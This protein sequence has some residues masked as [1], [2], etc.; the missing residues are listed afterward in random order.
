VPT[1]L[2]SLPCGV[3]SS[4]WSPSSGCGAWVVTTGR[5]VCLD[6]APGLVVIVRCLYLCRGGPHSSCLSPS[7]NRSASR[8][9]RAPRLN[10]PRD[11]RL[12]ST[13]SEAAAA[14]IARN[15]A[16]HYNNPAGIPS[17]QGIKRTKPP[18][19]PSAIEPDLTIVDSVGE[20]GEHCN[21]AWWSY[22][23]VAPR[24]SDSSSPVTLVLRLVTLNRFGA[25]A[26]RI[27]Y[28]RAK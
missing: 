24:A 28:R 16:D 8:D 11:S 12:C 18:P 3:K 4:G 14:R 2:G 13:Y 27:D 22:C 21:A 19:P 7:T 15:L 10:H 9:F 23:D 6:C 1:R 17:Q 20:I 26:G 5:K 25:S